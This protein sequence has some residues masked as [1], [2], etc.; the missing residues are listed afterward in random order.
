MKRQL[1]SAPTQ[2]VLLG[3]SSSPP[4]QETV[5]AATSQPPLATAIPGV[6]K[7][8][9][10]LPPGVDTS[11]SFLAN[12]LLSFQL[13]CLQHEVRGK[14]AYVY[15]LLIVICVAVCFPVITVTYVNSCQ[16]KSTVAFDIKSTDY[17]SLLNNPNIYFC[18]SFSTELVIQTNTDAGPIFAPFCCSLRGI[19]YAEHNSQQCAKFKEN[20]KTYEACTYKDGFYCG[21]LSDNTA[22][23]STLAYVTIDYVECVEASQAIVFAYQWTMYGLIVCSLLYIVLR[24]LLTSKPHIREAGVL[25]RP[26][27][28]VIM[29]NTDR[30]AHLVERITN[31][32][33]KT[34]REQEMPV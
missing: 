20:K 23:Y 10:V 9:S 32:V 19:K 4:R 13:G 15:V 5:L 29:N 6:T 11:I 33:L 12:S 30:H 31:Q 2:T 1:D 28:E 7:T 8:E 3:Q 25:S 16:L 21:E 14:W 17:M 26:S 18:G 27:W 22:Y 34:I 24:R